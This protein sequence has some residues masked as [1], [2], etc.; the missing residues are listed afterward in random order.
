MMPICISN[1]LVQPL[2]FL[3]FLILFLFLILIAKDFVVQRNP[4]ST[5]IPFHLL[6]S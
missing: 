1:A 6:Y 2:F 4:S 3:F 5:C